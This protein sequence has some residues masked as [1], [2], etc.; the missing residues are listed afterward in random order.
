M[1]EHHVNTGL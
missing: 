1:I